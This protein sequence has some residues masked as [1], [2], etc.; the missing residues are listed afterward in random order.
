MTKEVR[1]YNREKAVS[2]MGGARKLRQL[3]VK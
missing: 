3:H 2:S 1:L